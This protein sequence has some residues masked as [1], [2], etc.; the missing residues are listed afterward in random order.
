MSGALC[1]KMAGSAQ[2]KSSFW[3]G[4]SAEVPIHSSSST[5]SSIRAP[6][7]ECDLGAPLIWQIDKRSKRSAIAAHVRAKSSPHEWLCS[8]SVETLRFR[9]RAVASANKAHGGR[10]RSIKLRASSEDSVSPLSPDWRTGTDSDSPQWGIDGSSDGP[11]LPVENG[12]HDFQNDLLGE[13]AVGRQGHKENGGGRKAIDGVASNGHS[14]V[15]VR[16]GTG[17]LDCR[18]WSSR[19]RTGAFEFNNRPELRNCSCKARSLSVTS[20][21]CRVESRQGS[22]EWTSEAPLLRCILTCLVQKQ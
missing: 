11:V 7:W 18:V 15:Q 8:P 16:K 1:F 13:S 21:N 2:L 19:S 22:I 17:L 9:R 5:P 10:S 20:G 12:V 4:R 6:C 3:G 14:F